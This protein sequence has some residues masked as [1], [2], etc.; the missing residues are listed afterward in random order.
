[1][2]LALFVYLD[3]WYFQDTTIFAEL[4]LLLIVNMQLNFEKSLHDREIKSWSSQS[5]LC[6]EGYSTR[7]F[8]QPS[9]PVQPETNVLHY[10][11]AKWIWKP[12]SA[13]TR[14]QHPALCPSLFCHLFLLL[15]L[16]VGGS[17]ILGNVPSRYNLVQSFVLQWLPGCLL[18]AVGMA[19]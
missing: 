18:S 3:R 1:M 14:D 10:Y 7:F 15:Q 9:S 11:C 19:I 17:F 13:L 5:H 16:N 12:T 8:Y 2:V 4:D 6:R